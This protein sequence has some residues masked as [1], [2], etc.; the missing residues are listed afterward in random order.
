MFK[1]A[2]QDKGDNPPDL[3]HVSLTWIAGK[4]EEW[5]R[6]GAPVRDRIVNRRTRI[7]SFRPG[8]IFALVR[9]AANDFGT[10]ASHID[11][12]RAMGRYEACTTLPC[13]DPGGELLLHVAGWPKVSQVLHAIDTVE[14]IGIDAHVADPD[15]WRQVHHRIAAGQL[16]SEY[17]SCRHRAWLKRKAVWQ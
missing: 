1:P 7:A 12:V 17:S 16:P 4:R 14:A 13:I 15:H 11:I 10:I 9:W 5:L 2:V 3:T 6:F 8:A